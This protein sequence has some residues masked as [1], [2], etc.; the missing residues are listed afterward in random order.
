MRLSTKLVTI[1]FLMALLLTA[2]E[3]AIQSNDPV[4]VVA[5]PI[6]PDAD[7]VTYRHSS[8]VFTLRVPPDWIAGELPDPNG[9]RVQ[10]TTLEGEQAITRLSVYIVNTGQPMTPEVVRGGRQC[11]PAAERSRRV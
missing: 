5:T 4:F 7:F 2:C 8:G 11:L 1:L 10:F 9:V 3:G 6:P